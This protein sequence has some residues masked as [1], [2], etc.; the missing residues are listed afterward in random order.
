MALKKRKRKKGEREGNNEQKEEK[1]G[2]EGARGGSRGGGKADLVLG[3]G[4]ALRLCSGSCWGFSRPVASGSRPWPTTEDNVRQ[5]CL[6]MCFLLAL[7]VCFL[8][9]WQWTRLG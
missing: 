7:F 9:F 1:D 4:S 5:A 6:V 3:G 8:F 2:G